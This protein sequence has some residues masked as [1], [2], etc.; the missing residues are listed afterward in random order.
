M[1]MIVAVVVLVSFLIISC[2]QESSSPA[3]PPPRIQPGESIGGIALGMTTG[4]VRERL[5]APDVEKPSELHG[6]WT[7]WVYRDSGI[8]VTFDGSNDVWDVRTVAGE[9][10]TASGLGVGSTEAKLREAF[11]GL[12][13][14]PAGPEGTAP[15]RSCVDTRRHPGP[16]TRFWLSDGRVVSRV[17]VARGLAQ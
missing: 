8:R 11:P 17:T 12:R 6:G 15:P 9:Y 1:R 16:F 4:Q 14:G 2:G 5:G 3:D 7:Q 13:C 10:R